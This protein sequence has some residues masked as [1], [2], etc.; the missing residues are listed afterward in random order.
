MPGP[1]FLSGDRI[2]LR[3]VEE[4]DLDFLQTTVNDRAVRQ[5]LG[6]RSPVNG[7]REREWY[8]EKASDDETTHLLI[9][10]DGEPMGIVGLYPEDSKGVNAEVAI[11]LAEEFWGEGYGTEASRLI[12]D[13]AFRERRH[14]RVVAHVFSANVGSARI[15]EKL[16]FRHESTHVE[17]EFLDGEYVDVELYAILE[18][19]WFDRDA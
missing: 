5:Y 13:Y 8:E 16:G 9:C 4:E 6:N 14:H 15:W 2:D 1:V 10:R 18:D 11:F 3:T 19:E 17:A 7:H 12:T